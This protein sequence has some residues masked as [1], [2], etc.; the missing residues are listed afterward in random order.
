[1]HVHT[2]TQ[3][4]THPQV[5][6]KTYI[7]ETHTSP[8]IENPLRGGRDV[9]QDDILGIVLGRHVTTNYAAMCPKVLIGLAAMVN[10]F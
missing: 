10:P 8:L 1:M 2:S 9:L 3:H 5:Q 7:G 4:N 6:L